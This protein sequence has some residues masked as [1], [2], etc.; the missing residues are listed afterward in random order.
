MGTISA[1]MGV[2]VVSLLLVFYFSVKVFINNRIHF[3]LKLVC[4]IVSLAISVVFLRMIAILGIYF[5]IAS[6]RSVVMF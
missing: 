3:I 2:Y 1:I 5:F 6:G 4:G